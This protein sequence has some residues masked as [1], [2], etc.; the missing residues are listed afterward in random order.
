MR[1]TLAWERYDPEEMEPFLRELTRRLEEHPAVAGAATATQF[2][3]QVFGQ[4]GFRVEGGELGPE[5]TLPT[6]YT[7][8][9]S[10]DYFHVLGVPLLA[11]R[12]L[13]EA[14]RPGGSMVVVI[15]QAAADR[16][17][18]AGA[19]GKRVRLGGPDS[20]EPWFEVVGVVE[21]TRNRGLDAP[22]APEI[23]ASVRQLPSSSN[24]HFLL[25]R[26]PG[27][28]VA[29]LP[30]VR[31]T[32]HALDPQQPIYAIRTVDEAFEG[33]AAQRRIAATTLA[34]FGLF[35]LILAAVGIYAMVAYAVTQ[36]TREI[37]LRMALGAG[38]RSVHGL[39]VRQALVPVV[40]G[41]VVGLAGAV[42]L[43]RLLGA[44]LFGIGSTDP[45]TYAAV[46]LVF[47]ITAVTASWI[48][49]RRASRLDPLRALREEKG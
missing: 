22:P 29:V 14:D 25:I 32:V 33:S 42:V 9:V 15:N 12:T 36:R 30:A 23:F 44:L 1:L 39:V 31:E 17:F 4:A 37:A 16:Y 46:V 41:A 3:P 18:P 13:T 49:A 27:S 2:P 35:A 8:I 38:R 21:S 28:G 20:E 47:G 11:G 26:A 19:V 7:T 6:A 43:G 48:P 34:L 5:E 40:V 24:Q 10:P 45:L